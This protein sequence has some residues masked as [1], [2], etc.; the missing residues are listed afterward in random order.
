MQVLYITAKVHFFFKVHISI[1]IKYLNQ[2]NNKGWHLP[3]ALSRAR[4]WLHTM[5]YWPLQCCGCQRAWKTI[6]LHMAGGNHRP[7]GSEET[8]CQ[9]PQRVV[10]DVIPCACDAYELKLSSYHSVPENA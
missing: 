7:D 8:E 3:V 2:T 10:L 5:A 6:L 9:K 1:R 4:M